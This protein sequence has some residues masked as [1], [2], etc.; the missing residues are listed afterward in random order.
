MLSSFQPRSPLRARH[1][2]SQSRYDDACTM[3]IIVELQLRDVCTPTPTRSSPDCNCY[4]CYTQWWRDID[5]IFCC[6]RNPG[7]LLNCFFQTL[8]RNLGAIAATPPDLFGVLR[9]SA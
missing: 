2:K 6:L 1:E 8:R 7:L 3:F 9:Q 4:R 5:V